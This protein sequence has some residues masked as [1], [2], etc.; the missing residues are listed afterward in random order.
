M[1]A[2]PSK[3]ELLDDG[4]RY[5]K[6]VKNDEDQ[7]LDVSCN[8]G[9]IHFKCKTLMADN[10]AWIQLSEDFGTVFYQP[11]ERGNVPLTNTFIVYAFSASGYLLHIKKD[12]R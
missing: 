1:H 3:C 11:E 8:G 5:F 2:F 10:V 6:V 9:I 7:T 4:Y 12:Q